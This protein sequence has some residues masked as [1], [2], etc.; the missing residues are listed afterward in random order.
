MTRG[1]SIGQRAEIRTFSK[2][3]ESSPCCRALFI[4]LF[5]RRMCHWCSGRG[6]E[7]SDGVIPWRY[8]PPLYLRHPRLLLL[9]ILVTSLHGFQDVPKLHQATSTH[10]MAEVRCV[11]VSPR[12]WTDGASVHKKRVGGGGGASVVSNNTSVD[13]ALRTDMR[14]HNS[15]PPHPHPRSEAPVEG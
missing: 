7:V 3:A 4:H 10:H 6:P 14:F 5:V 8:S 15:N 9:T 12:C 1:N 13:G 2:V 11:A